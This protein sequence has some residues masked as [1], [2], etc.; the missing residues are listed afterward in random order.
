MLTTVLLLAAVVGVSL[1]A[2]ARL[3]LEQAPEQ[4]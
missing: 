3:G 2:I 1:S 4:N